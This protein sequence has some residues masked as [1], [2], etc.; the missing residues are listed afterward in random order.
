MVFAHLILTFFLLPD[1]AFSIIIISSSSSSSI[2]SSSSTGF[3]PRPRPLPLPLPDCGVYNTKT[4]LSVST[5]YTMRLQKWL[6]WDGIIISNIM[7]Q[8]LLNWAEFNAP[9]DTVQFILEAVF[10]ANHLEVTDKVICMSIKRH[11]IHEL[12]H[13]KYPGL[14]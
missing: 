4:D 14:K 1:F 6:K 5:Q 11:T 2:S 8:L 12:K 10:T 13:V 3:L 7:L 9:P